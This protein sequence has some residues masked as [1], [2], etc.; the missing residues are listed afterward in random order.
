MSVLTQEEA[1]KLLCP[2]ATSFDGHHSAD[3]KYGARCATEACLAWSLILPDKPA[4]AP[5]QRRGFCKRLH[6]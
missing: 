3:G 6:P 4:I 5:A 1:S 2:F